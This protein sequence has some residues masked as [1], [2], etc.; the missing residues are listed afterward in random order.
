MPAWCTWPEVHDNNFKVQSLS[1]VHEI[2]QTC[3]P[4]CLLNKKKII[5]HFWELILSHSRKTVHG[6]IE[7]SQIVG[8]ALDLASTFWCF[9]NCTS[10][11]SFY[12]G[13]YWWCSEMR[14]FKW[15]STLTCAALQCMWS[16][17]SNSRIFDISSM[18]RVH[19]LRLLKLRNWNSRQ[20]HP[21]GHC[22]Y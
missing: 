13:E 4:T 17:I 12:S 9:A 3:L 11:I 8:G 6:E 14:G 20:N 18:I 5:G 10:A 15:S 2:T 1:E 22:G 19:Q 16:S 7:S 21:S